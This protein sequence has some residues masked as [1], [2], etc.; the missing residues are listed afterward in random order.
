[1]ESSKPRRKTKRRK[2]Q[3]RGTNRTRADR[4]L[5]PGKWSEAHYPEPGPLYDAIEAYFRDCAAKGTPTT[6]PGLAYA[7]G[8]AVKQTVWDYMGKSDARAVIMKRAVLAIEKDRAAAFIATGAPGMRMDLINH[9][10]W[11]DKMEQIVAG[12]IDI[13]V[14]LT[15]IEAYQRSLK[16]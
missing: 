4:G 5:E 8:F 12:A 6:V 9:A 13:N 10:K 16:K 2:P 3:P 11:V 1:M 7:L 14:A 15:P